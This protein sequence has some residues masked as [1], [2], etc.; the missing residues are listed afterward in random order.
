MV[1]LLN[2]VSKV[3]F[4]QTVI[5]LKPACHSPTDYHGIG[6]LLTY[7]IFFFLSLFVAQL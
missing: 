1:Q 6:C 7:T 3:A 4:N 2:H 5:P